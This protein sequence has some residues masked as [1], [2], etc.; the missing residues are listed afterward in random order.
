MTAPTVFDETPLDLYRSVP[1]MHYSFDSGRNEMERMHHSS[2]EM[3]YNPDA[4]EI[5]PLA[6]DIDVPS[7]ASS[8]K[9][10]ARA[11]S[12]DM[13]MEVDEPMTISSTLIESLAK[14]TESSAADDNPFEPIPLSPASKRRPSLPREEVFP[15]ISRSLADT[16]EE[17]H[18]EV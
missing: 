18:E 3:Y 2:D 10:S 6:V 17:E 14:I 4:D 15:N 11:P 16:F 9:R 12:G 13:D 5:D 1:N 7:L 8:S